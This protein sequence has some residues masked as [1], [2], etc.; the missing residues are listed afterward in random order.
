[1]ALSREDEARAEA[2]ILNERYM[3]L[4]GRPYPLKKRMKTMK[5]RPWK[6]PSW[7]DVYIDRLS[8]AGVPD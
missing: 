3:K 2:K 7:I 5:S 6:D 8:K 1:M 4:K